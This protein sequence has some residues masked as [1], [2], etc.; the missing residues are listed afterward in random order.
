MIWYFEKRIYLHTKSWGSADC[1]LF[2]FFWGLDKSFGAVLLKYFCLGKLIKKC[3]NLILI[4]M[5]DIY[6]LDIS[7]LRTRLL[8]LIILDFESGHGSVPV[9]LKQWCELTW[10]LTEAVIVRAWEFCLG[11]KTTCCFL[12][13]LY[14]IPHVLDLETQSWK[15]SVTWSNWH[16]IMFTPA[17][18]SFIFSHLFKKKLLYRNVLQLDRYWVWLSIHDYFTSFEFSCSDVFS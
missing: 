4:H 15:F 16:H 8:S 11:H 7:E 14:H 12:H 1:Y 6:S 10:C 5:Y 13:S 2:Y 17:G 3:H 9:W 18:A